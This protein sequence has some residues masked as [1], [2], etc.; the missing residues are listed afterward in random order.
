M[1][2]GS[3]METT[4]PF[5]F[6]PQK[7]LEA[8]LYIADRLP[9]RAT[10]LIL[11]KVFYMTD[12]LS[13]EMYGRF[14]CGDRYVAMEYGPVPSGVYDI[15]KGKLPVDPTAFRTS[16]YYINPNRPPN[17]TLLSESDMEC[18]DSVLR[19][20]GKRI[21]RLIEDSHDGAWEGTAEN[22]VIQV[23]HIAD[24]LPDARMIIEHLHE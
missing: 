21:G 13:L 19:K 24:T 1:V 16:G 17:E 4:P 6:D 12:K 9:C 14:T 10:R 20:Y 22:A 5:R 7:A 3:L 23:E 2:G 15:I 11:S 8:I 18:L